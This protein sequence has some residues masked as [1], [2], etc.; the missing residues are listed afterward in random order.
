MHHKSKSFRDSYNALPQQTKE[1]ADKN[2]GFLKDNPPHPS[3][4]FKKVDQKRNIYSVR[5][6]NNYRALAVKEDDAYIWFWIG[7]HEEYFNTTSA[8]YTGQNSHSENFEMQWRIYCAFF[9]PV[10]YGIWHYCNYDGLSGRPS[11]R[12]FP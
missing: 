7:T 4:Y 9:V 3:L 11:G 5:V 10:L 1:L 6:G 8:K 2:Y 12:R